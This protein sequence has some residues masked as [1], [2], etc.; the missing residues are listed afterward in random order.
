MK[1]VK[2]AV[3]LV[4]IALAPSLARADDAPA[5]FRLQSALNLGGSGAGWDHIDYDPT[6]H[7][8]YLSRRGDGL[9]VVDTVAGKSLGEVA[10][11]KGSGAMDVAPKLD[12]GFTANGDGSSS[13][14]RLSDLA[15]IDRVSFGDNFDGVLYDDTTNLLA[16]QQPRNSR[17]IFVD[18]ATMKLLGAV[19]LEGK[20]PER[21][22]TDDKGVLYIAMRDTNLAYKID[23]R[24][25]K[26][27][28][29]WDVS[30]ACRQPSG[31]AFDVAGHRLLLPCRN[32]GEKPV[33]AVVDADT[34]AITATLPTGRG[35]DDVLLDSAGARLF[36]PCGT[37]AV[38]NIFHRDGPDAYTLSETLQSRP[39]MRTARYDAESRR[40]Y[41]ITA[42][43][44]FDPAKKP[45]PR[46]GAQGP[47][48]FFRGTFV[49]LTFG[50]GQP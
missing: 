1:R 8:A 35:A 48:A 11:A 14:F 7:R 25:R 22:V 32:D 38:V 28:A 5:F 34:G 36:V 33:I 41:G 40:L 50:L 15:P 45:N 43:G 47:N 3:F 2:T 19:E 30:S 9:T 13:V 24:E 20:E 12:R 26:I 29:K 6:A 17:E 44:Y 31:S 4:S 46:A 27:L 49:F 23:M 18:P 39:G 21:P 16:Y 42:E 10:N 37:D